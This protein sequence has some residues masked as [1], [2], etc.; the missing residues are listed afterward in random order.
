MVQIRLKKPNALLFDITGTVAKTSFIDKVLLPY[1]KTQFFQ[2]MEENWGSKFA[3]I[4][5]QALKEESEKEEQAPKVKLDGNRDS[6]TQSA[7]A[8]VNYCLENHKENR[9]MTLLK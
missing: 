6:Q 8:Y 7:F 5:L 2:Y 1:I 4:D 9:A 3:Q